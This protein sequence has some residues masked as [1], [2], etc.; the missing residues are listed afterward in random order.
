MEKYCCLICQREMDVLPKALYTDYHCRDQSDHHFAWRIR[1]N[2]MT[3]LRIRLT[4]PEENLY[5]KVH[6]DENYSEVWA[7]NRLTQ[8]IR[9]DQIIVPD[10]GDMDKLKNKI[11]TIL[12]FS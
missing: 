3:K 6:Y 11:R 10:F 8:R 7:H 2:R 4:T 1:D 9:V 12:T 5:L